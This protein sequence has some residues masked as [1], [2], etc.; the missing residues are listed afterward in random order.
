M[1]GRKKR[2]ENVLDELDRQDLIK[3]V[4]DM[5]KDTDDQIER[6]K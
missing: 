3:L 4:E 1:T 6:L 2:C 5:I